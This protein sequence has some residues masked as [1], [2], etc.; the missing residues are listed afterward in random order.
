MPYKNKLNF[1]YDFGGGGTPEEFLTDDGREWFNSEEIRDR[2][3]DEGFSGRLY[4]TK[5]LADLSLSDAYVRFDGLDGTTENQDF[6]KCLSALAESG[7]NKHKKLECH[8]GN[9]LVTAATEDQR[10]SFYKVDQ[11]GK[12]VSAEGTGALERFSGLDFWGTENQTQLSEKLS[13]TRFAAVCGPN[14]ENDDLLIASRKG[15]EVIEGA[16]EIL[17]GRDEILSKLNDLTSHYTDRQGTECLLLIMAHKKAAGE[18]DP[19]HEE[20]LIRHLP[21]T[22][23]D[24]VQELASGTANTPTP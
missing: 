7:S 5:S 14:R 13:Q 22:T 8:E 18:L 11:Y 3:E 12:K 2:D 6:L 24:E 17:Q 10:P 15:V 21:E 9:Y 19:T 4:P 20:I 1:Y 23:W 16:A